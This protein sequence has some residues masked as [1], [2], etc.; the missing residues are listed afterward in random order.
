MN[1]KVQITGSLLAHNTIVNIL[2][3]V[4]PFFI[5]IFAIPFVI[6]GLGTERFGILSLAW[7]LLGYSAVFELG[8]GSPIT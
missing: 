8:L 3:R 4:L 5:T 6:K 1:N 7:A 2:G